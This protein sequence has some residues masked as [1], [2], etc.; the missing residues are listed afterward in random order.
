MKNITGKMYIRL[1]EERLQQIRALSEEIG[2]HY[3]NFGGMLLWMGFCAYMRQVA[4]E[5]LFSDEQLYKLGKMYV[6]DK[7]N[8]TN[9]ETTD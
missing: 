7:E 5:K 1:P 6:E 3:T 2:M 4:P 8:E 9:A